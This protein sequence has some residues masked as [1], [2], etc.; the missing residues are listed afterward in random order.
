MRRFM[1]V[2]LLSCML[3]G[4]TS[5]AWNWTEFARGAGNSMLKIGAGALV[6]GIAKSL[7][8]PSGRWDP[9]P[10]DN[11]MLGAILA[12]AYNVVMPP[13]R[14]LYNFTC[15]KTENFI[16]DGQKELDFSD[17]TKSYCAGA[18]LSNLAAFTCL[19]IASHKRPI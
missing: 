9:T 14:A 12:I 2:S 6:W 11:F 17:E 15:P 16:E 1:L 4:Q 18:L 8:G 10:R 7:T 5:S 3:V 13:S 19:I